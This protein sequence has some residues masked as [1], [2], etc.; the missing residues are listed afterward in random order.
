[1]VRPLVEIELVEAGP[2]DL[3]GYDWLVLTS[4]TGARE[5]RRRAR[6]RPA[7]VAAEATTADVDG[8]VAAVAAAE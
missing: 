4:A 7:R 6:G 3:D 1:V 8:L 2:V 5:L